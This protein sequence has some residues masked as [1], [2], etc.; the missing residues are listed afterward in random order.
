MIITVRTNEKLK[1]TNH[2]LSSYIPSN[3][4]MAWFPRLCRTFSTQQ[5]SK[6][7][8]RVALEWTPNTNH[9][10]FYVARANGYYAEHNLDIELISPD[11]DG[12]KLTPG[13]RAISGEADFAMGPTETAI[14]SAT[15][16]PDKMRLLSIATLL[17]KSTSAVVTLQS[18]NINNI[19][20]MRRY[21]SY[22]GRFE[23]PII[24]QMIRNN[25]GDPDLLEEIKTS[26]LDIWP[27]MM[28]NLK[29]ADSTWIF[30]QWEGVEAAMNGVEL[31]V[32]RLEDYGIPYGYSP[33]LLA[34]EDVLHSQPDVV[35]DFV[36]ATKRGYEFAAQSEN[37]DEC[38]DILITDSGYVD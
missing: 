2:S 25:K 32:F 16:D 31:N 7:H 34:R 12:Y 13:R 26:K 27:S 15:T 9:I 22:E 14:S 3:Q 11:I 36:A 17:Q 37:V 33:V 18:S 24:R 19:N 38:T 29:E 8:L 4:V 23:M 35:R 5:H 6:H 20:D 1:S 30:M 10:G 28:N 21:A